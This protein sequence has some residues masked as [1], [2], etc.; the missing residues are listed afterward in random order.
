MKGFILF[1]EK[2]NNGTIIV[3]KKRRRWKRASTQS[4]I[5]FK[6]DTFPIDYKNP[7]H[8]EKNKYTYMIDI[9]SKKQITSNDLKEIDIGVSLT[10]WNIAFGEETVKQLVYEATM[11]TLGGMSIMMAIIILIAGL[12]A[13]LFFGAQ[14]L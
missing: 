2:I 10:L 9:T 12:F 11:P 14:F 6:K 8:Q 4:S 13:G 1:C 3:G 5:K 7:I